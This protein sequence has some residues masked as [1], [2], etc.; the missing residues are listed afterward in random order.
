[1]KKILTDIKTYWLP[2]VIIFIY[3]A[4][5]YIFFGNICPMQILIGIPCPGCGLTRACLSILTWRL[6]DAWSYNATSFLWISAILY[7]IWRRYFSMRKGKGGVTT[8]II[9]IL[10]LVT[11]AYYVFRMITI[12]P[13][14]PMSYFEGNLLKLYI[15]IF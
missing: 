14:S 15:N 5:T 12:F 11:M 13:Q 1:M 3:L 6:K 7:G 10:G 9:V 2:I 8:A 4:I